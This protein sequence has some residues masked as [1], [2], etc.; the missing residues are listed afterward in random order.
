[1]SITPETARALVRIAAPLSI[2]C[3]AMSSMVGC[4]GGGTGPTQPPLGPDLNGIPISGG[5]AKPGSPVPSGAT[6]PTAA[7]VQTIKPVVPTP[8]QAT[9]PPASIFATPTPAPTIRPTPQ[10]VGLGIHIDQGATSSSPFR[11]NEFFIRFEGDN[12]LR[13]DLPSRRTYSALLLMGVSQAMA[14]SA[15]FRPGVYA[16]QSAKVNWSLSNPG[17]LHTNAVAGSL[18]PKNAAWFVV[19]DGTA[20]T[21][22]A[23]SSVIIE[24]GP[25]KVGTLLTFTATVSV[26]TDSTFADDGAKTVAVEILASN[27]GQVDFVIQSLES[28]VPRPAR[29]VP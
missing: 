11:L 16:T 19:G 23:S 28:R 29:L 14:A 7:P 22:P 21:V 27:E 13:P 10:L 2:A 12:L 5:T 4:P 15:D 1:M 20:S 26:A 9:P 25:A 8:A 18:N 3:L 24:A 6:L 17:I